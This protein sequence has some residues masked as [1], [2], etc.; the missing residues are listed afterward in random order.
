MS[1]SF[2]LLKNWSL[3]TQLEGMYNVNY[4]QGRDLELYRNQVWMANGN[5]SSTFLLNKNVDWNLEIGNT[6]ASPTIQGPFKI[7]GYSSTYLL[8]NRKFFNKKFEVNVSFMDIFKTEKQRVSSKYADQNNY[9]NDYRDT[10]KVNVTLRYHFGN[11]KIKNSA[12]VP[13]KTEE[14]G[15]L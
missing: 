8:T 10:R 5:V 14:Q 12:N 9:Y 1:K 13:K 7:S 4:Y 11:Q 3:N 15:R 6:F 2:Q